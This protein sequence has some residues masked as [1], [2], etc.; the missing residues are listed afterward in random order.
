MYIYLTSNSLLSDNQS[1]YRPNDSCINQLISITSEIFEAFEGY[2]EVRAVFLDIS[3]AFD[4]VWYEGLI[5]KLERC[6]IKGNLLN[7]IKNYLHNRKQRVVLNGQE[8][9]WVTLYS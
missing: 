7:L 5:F 9:G 1:G 8:S 6:G 2:D 3:K 4:K